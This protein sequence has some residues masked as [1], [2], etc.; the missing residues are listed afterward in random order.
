MI[1]ADKDPQK[2]IIIKGQ[3]AWLLKTTMWPYHRTSWWW[4]LAGM[5]MGPGKSSL[6]LIR[7]MPKI[8]PLCKRSF[9][10]TPA[11]LGR[12]NKPDVVILKVLPL[13]SYIGQRLL[14]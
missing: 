11:S 14:Q 2:H 1:K 9:I 8:A 10:L 5:K 13:R 3:G 12:M 7:C 4:L 6:A